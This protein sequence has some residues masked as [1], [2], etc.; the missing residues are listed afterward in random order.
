M[1]CAGNRSRPNRCRALFFKADL[2]NCHCPEFACMNAMIFLRKLGVMAECSWEYVNRLAR[3]IVCMYP[4][5]PIRRTRS[6]LVNATTRAD[7]A[8]ATSQRR[9]SAA[10]TTSVRA[11][12]RILR[13]CATLWRGR[14]RP[15]ATNISISKPMNFAINRPP[16]KILCARFGRNSI[17][18][19]SSVWR[20]CDYGKQRTI[21][22][23]CAERSTTVLSVR[24]LVSR[25]L[26][27][28]AGRCHAKSFSTEPGALYIINAYDK[29][30]RER[31]YRQHHRLRCRIG[32]F[33][34]R[35]VLLGQIS[36]TPEIREKS[37]SVRL[38]S[39]RGESRKYSRV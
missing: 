18:R 3:R 31:H 11:R 21:V 7:T 4:L 35:R 20:V 34:D 36:G 25:R 1:H 26:E 28:C 29:K 2:T 39:L 27:T 5:F 17:T 19:F 14:L 6:S 23:P 32:D 33:P 12:W 13:N 16:A 37:G 24:M 9:Q 15:G 8:I 10:N 22:S 38:L 30:T